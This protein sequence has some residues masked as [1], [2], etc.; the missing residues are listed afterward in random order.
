[1]TI[2]LLM[3]FSFF[4]AIWQS[5]TRWSWM[6]SKAYL[7]EHPFISW[8]IAFIDTPIVGSIYMSIWNNVLAP[9]FGWHQISIDTAWLMY[10]FLIQF[11]PYPT[12]IIEVSK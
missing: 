3:V 7:K 2:T 9:S 1:M 5:G 6:S 11:F 8:T 10:G 12:K 4:Y